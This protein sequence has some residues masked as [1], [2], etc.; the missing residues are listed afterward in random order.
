M[1]GTASSRHELHPV[2]PPSRQ[3]PAHVLRRG[4]DRSPLVRLYRRVLPARVRRVVVTGTSAGARSRVKRCLTAVPGP[5]HV[6]GIVRAARAARRTARAGAGQDQAVRL[7][8]D[9]P[10]IVTVRDDVSPLWVRNANSAAV[11]AALRSAG[12]D[13]FCVRGRS[14]SAAVVA[15]A[16]DDRQ[17][18]LNALE[19]ACRTRPGY[20]CATDRQWRTR[21][22]FRHATWRRLASAD[23]IRVTWYYSDRRGLLTLGP[24]YGCD[25]EFWTSEADLLVA[26]RRNRKAEEV[27]RHGTEVRA[28][29]SFFTWLAPA[30]APLPTVRT[31]DEF[32]H[33]APDDIRFPVD[34]VYTWV[35]G[36]DP[37]W[38]RSRA[39]CAGPG[40][41]EE[42]ANSARFLDRDELRYSLRSLRQYAPWVRTIYLVTD[43]QVPSWLDTSVPGLRV[44]GHKEIFS[45]PSLLPTF[46]SQAI[47][48]QLHHIDGL[49]EHFLY[50]NDDVL[51]G[52]LTTAQDFFLA[53]GL[54]KF[55][56]ST[57][58]IP[59]G[60]PCAGDVPVAAAGK[61][62]R[63][64]LEA[65]F[66]TVIS[67]KMKHTPHALRRSVLYE[68]EAR[69]P[70][71]HRATA[72][73]RL[74][75]PEDLSIVSALHHYYAFLTARAVPGRLRYAYLD[76]SHPALTARLDSLLARR[77][78]HVF[79]L[80]DTVSGE[81]EAASQQAALSGFLEAYYPVRGPY[82]LTP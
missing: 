51:L 21:P 31:R 80:N 45:D 71:E 24:T 82:E 65:A 33:P 15:V 67:H 13:Y 29:D 44:I 42:A 17:A 59:P 52:R 10:K 56:P 2:V 49:S 77:D 30:A 48:S 1:F 57:V 25:V 70:L 11:R 40:Y 53:N 46:N 73:H 36:S 78:R 18:A 5:R 32:A 4:P 6:L 64:L 43:E 60:P 41:H 19:E 3:V 37:E 47:E 12:I 79:C 39:A 28:S 58:L 38:L 9:V 34:V 23:V 81:E 62:N 16:A 22:G 68:I 7:V 20:V 75:S 76:L 55:F 27:P 66:G 69:F 26:P 50:F 74:R 14:H 63:A 54:T 35:D 72:G 8:R 61:N